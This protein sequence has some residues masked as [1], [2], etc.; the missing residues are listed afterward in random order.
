[1]II[2]VCLT[3]TLERNWIIPKFSIGGFFRVQQELVFAAGK[4]VNVARVIKK[5]NG[6]VMCI[7][8]I[9]GFV[10]Q[11]FKSLVD[12]EGIQG[13]WTETR[14]ETRESITV[15]DP[16]ASGDATSF[17]PHGPVIGESEWVSFVT[18]FRTL[19]ENV[20][21]ICF[22]GN[23]PPGISAEQLSTLISELGG[24]GNQVWLDISG[25]MLAAGARAAPFAIKV[26][27]SE[28]S[29]LAGQMVRN[30]KEALEVSRNLREVYDI[31]MIIVTLGSGGSVCSSEWG[32]WI[33]HPV[34]YPKIISS[35]GSGDAFLGGLLVQYEKG[36]SLRECLHVA[37][38]AA[39]AN[40]QQLG[41]GVFTAGDYQHAFEKTVVESVSAILI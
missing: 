31:P 23:I 28:I 18:Q 4:G 41:P 19:A 1:M 11:Y 32:D 6:Q 27:S 22:S 12:Q 26:N 25:P 9:G 24:R 38:A 33:A 5:L 2:S 36:A 17:C 16:E 35:I 21:T 37:S 40:T 39:S 10:G 34:S 29:E 30:R 8:F 13:N 15:F 7:G 3:S 14:T 20:K